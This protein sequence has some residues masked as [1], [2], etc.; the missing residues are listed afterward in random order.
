MVS[1][2]HY[3]SARTPMKLVLRLLLCPAV[4]LL[5]RALKHLMFLY[6]L[7]VCLL[8]IL[9]VWGRLLRSL[10]TP[11]LIY[12]SARILPMPPLLWLTP[13]YEFCTLR[14]RRSC[15]VPTPSLTGRAPPVPLRLPLSVR[16]L[17]T[18]M[19]R[20]STPRAHIFFSRYCLAHR[21]CFRTWLTLCSDTHRSLLHGRSFRRFNA[22]PTVV[23]GAMFLPCALIFHDT[24]H[25]HC[26]LHWRSC[27]IVL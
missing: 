2:H 10:I 21:T 7:E 25:V 6:V 1:R 23:T 18:T 16:L 9:R 11:W 26:D 17:R 8:W 27:L 14:C 19:C 24:L 3:F 15:L 4:F 5:Y 12:P 13:R 22:Q 20:V